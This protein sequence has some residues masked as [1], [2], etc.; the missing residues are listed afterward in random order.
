MPEGQGVV[1]T[2][3]GLVLPPRA[4]LAAAD[5][6]FQG[7]SAVSLLPSIDG[8]P[9]ATGAAVHGFKPPP[10]A[11]AADRAVQ[12]AVFAADEAWAGAGLERSSPP[13]ERIATVV[14]LS[15]GPLRTL[16]HLA[17]HP[18]DTAPLWPALSPD[19]AATAIAL[20]RGL[21]GPVLAPV[22]ACASGGHALAWGAS[23]IARGC[24]DAAV[25]GAAEASLH[26]LVIGSYRRM[27]VL[28]D[29]GDD[30]VRSVRPFSATRRGFAIGEGAGILVLESEASA[31]RRG[32]RPLA[33]IRG[34]ATGSQAC[35]LAA[36][37]PTG[38]ALSRLIAGVLARAGLA[39][40]AVDYIH[41]HG[42]ATPD[43]DAVEARA[44]CRA[45]GPAAARVSVS[46]TKGSHGH[47]LGAAT[48]VELVLTVLAMRRGEA[49]PT[50]NLTDPDPAIR[51]DCTPLAARRRP[52]RCA[53][54]M[55]SGF[56]GQM[57]AIVLTSP[58]KI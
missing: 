30:P 56:G 4:G 52:M 24:V 34:W 58:G 11:E 50:A 8:I 32:A 21:A 3:L 51:L 48:A 37:E 39:A 15:K 41:A 16:A 6:T 20:R 35:G 9:D 7:R 31:A 23:L 10:G 33:C 43:N 27:G 57:A 13:P 25:V 26:P 14:S 44:I 17:R 42:T 49:P 47:L 29:G 36:M 45:L 2:G 1:I 54:K 55:A 18:R 53:L 12:F 40:E 46:S 22:T 5:A 28:A 38:E 19:A